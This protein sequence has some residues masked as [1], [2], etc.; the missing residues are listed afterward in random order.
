VFELECEPLDIALTVLRDAGL[1][2][3]VALYG[4]T[5]HVID[6][7]AREKISIAQNLLGEKNVKVTRAREII[8]SLE[9]AFIARLRSADRVANGNSE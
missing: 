5:V 8:A 6:P 4:S 9:D 3:E 7:N 2:D 1:F